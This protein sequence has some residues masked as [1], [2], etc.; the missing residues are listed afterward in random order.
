[1]ETEKIPFE[2]RQAFLEDKYKFS[3]EMLHKMIVGEQYG[4][5]MLNFDQCEVETAEA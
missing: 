2:H 3:D 1:M 4:Q 5:I